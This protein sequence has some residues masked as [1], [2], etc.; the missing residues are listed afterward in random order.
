[1]LNFFWNKYI[2]ML[3]TISSQKVSLQISTNCKCKLWKK[4]AAVTWQTKRRNLF[5]IWN[6]KRLYLNQH[7]LFLFYLLFICLIYTQMK[8]SIVFCRHSRTLMSSLKDD[9]DVTVLNNKTSVCLAPILKLINYVLNE[10]I[11]II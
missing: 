7:L 8:N 1:M 11:S 9:Y 6:E 10:Y 2:L 3:S 5:G 4:L